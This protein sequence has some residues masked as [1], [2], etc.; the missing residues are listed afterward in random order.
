MPHNKVH[1]PSSAV[2][3]VGVEGTSCPYIGEKE[4][5]DEVSSLS[6]ITIR[7]LHQRSLQAQASISLPPQIYKRYLIPTVQYN[8]YRPIIHGPSSAAKKLSPAKRQSVRICFET[9]TSSTTSRHLPPNQNLKPSRFVQNT[10]QYQQTVQ[11]QIWCLVQYF[12]SYIIHT[13][14]ASIVEAQP[15]S[16]T[17]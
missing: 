2:A 12:K 4:E 15:L 1:G 11:S 7:P 6:V 16:S 14:Q 3:L 13:H 10:T 17:Q 9:I 5:H 8:R